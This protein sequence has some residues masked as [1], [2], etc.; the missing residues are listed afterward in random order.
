MWYVVKLRHL[1]C[2]LY[3][4]FNGKANG[5]TAVIFFPSI[6]QISF[7][8]VRDLKKCFLFLRKHISLLTKKTYKTMSL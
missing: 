7:Y 6:L 8:N 3:P 5:T 4:I 1:F 2:G